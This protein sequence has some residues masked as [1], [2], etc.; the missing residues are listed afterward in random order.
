M[1]RMRSQPS[2]ICA[3][4]IANRNWMRRA[5]CAC[6]MVTLLGELG[7]GRMTYRSERSC[8]HMA[9]VCVSI[10]VDMERED[11][12]DGEDDTY[13]EKCIG[14]RSVEEHRPVHQPPD[15]E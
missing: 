11:E 7:S 2:T 13:Q 14:S 4:A 15:V 6:V 10:T 8:Y 9:C 3:T 12:G 1:P 5:L